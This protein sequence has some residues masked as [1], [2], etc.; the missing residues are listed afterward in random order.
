[1]FFHGGREQKNINEFV[2]NYKYKFTRAK[3]KHFDSKRSEILA[4]YQFPLII[5]HNIFILT[6]FRRLGSVLVTAFSCILMAISFFAPIIRNLRLL[7][8]RFFFTGEKIV[9]DAFVQA[10]RQG[11]RY[12][13]KWLTLKSGLGWRGAHRELNE[14]VKLS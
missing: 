13:A 8:F 7:F 9:D 2:S 14:L 4:Q 12:L 6:A 3:S 10:G 5:L 1:M 11:Q